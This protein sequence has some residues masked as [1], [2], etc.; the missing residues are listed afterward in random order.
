[1]ACNCF[2]YL[3][4]FLN[5]K[6]SQITF[7]S[8]IAFSHL[9][10]LPFFESCYQNPIYQ[11]NCCINYLVPEPLLQ[12]STKQKLFLTFPLNFCL[13]TQAI[14]QYFTIEFFSIAVKFKSCFPVE[15]SKNLHTLL[16]KLKYISCS[17]KYL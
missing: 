5:S 6:Y 17:S 8:F 13:S 3:H 4:H 9:K 10:K 1:M 7:A 12:S 16:T 2:A 11:I 15:I 14:I